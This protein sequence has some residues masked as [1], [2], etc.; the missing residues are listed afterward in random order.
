LFSVGKLASQIGEVVEFGPGD[1]AREARSVDL[2]DACSFITEFVTAIA[3]HEARSS[4]SRSKKSRCACWP[5]QIFTE[6]DTDASA[7][8]SPSQLPQ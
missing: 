7:A 8:L 1:D 5:D 2:A 6:N 4:H 3:V